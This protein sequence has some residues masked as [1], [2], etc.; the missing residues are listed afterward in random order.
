MSVVTVVR[1]W[2]KMGQF[3]FSFSNFE[4][5]PNYDDIY[6]KTSLIASHV[7]ISYF[8]NYT[9]NFW[10]AGNYFNPQGALLNDRHI[11]EAL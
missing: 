1:S 6:W 8:A 5:F 10:R 2:F 9:I 4:T 7:Y 3:F 11:G